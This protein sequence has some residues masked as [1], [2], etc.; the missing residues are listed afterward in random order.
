MI[1]T[2]ADLKAARHALRWSL[3]EMAGALRLTGANAERMLRDME[4]GAKPVS[5]PIAV[6]VEAYLSGWRPAETPPDPES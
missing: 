3:S 4:A 5:G 6:A 1:E 2:G